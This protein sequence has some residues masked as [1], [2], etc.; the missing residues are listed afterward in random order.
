[1]SEDTTTT[2]TDASSEQP[3]EP[4]P[5]P[6]AAPAADTPHTFDADYVA[7]LRAESAK[8][9]TQAK[10]NAEA[11]K[12]LAE[13]E[14]STKTE[15]QKQAEQFAKLQQENER[16]HAQML[17]AQVAADKGVPADLLSGSTEE[18]L[19]AAADRLLAFRGAVPPAE[20]GRETDTAPTKKS[21]QLTKADLARMT[22]QQINDALEAGLLDDLN[23]GRTK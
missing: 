18:E 3:L 12:R 14:E 16:L 1:M 4:A 9:R 19:A 6:P 20:Y 23:A 21:K 2:T 8:Y 5:T 15:A 11:A 10:A 7:K 22:P 13:I 17:K